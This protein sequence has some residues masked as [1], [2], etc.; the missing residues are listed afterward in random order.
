MAVISERRKRESYARMALP[1]NPWELLKAAARNP[2]V[3]SGSGAYQSR[4]SAD[5]FGPRYGDLRS[6]ANEG[7]GKGVIGMKNSGAGA[8]AQPRWTRSFAIRICRL[9]L[10]WYWFYP[11]EA[12]ARRDGRIC[13]LKIPSASVRGVIQ[14]SKRQGRKHVEVDQMILCSVA[15]ITVCIRLN[16]AILHPKWR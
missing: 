3:G 14:L 1:A 6:Q 10:R 15:A 2:W 12:R 8:F 5:G 7:R 16:G 4:A 9:G 11:S 13:M